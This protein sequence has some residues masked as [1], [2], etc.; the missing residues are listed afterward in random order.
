METL[1]EIIPKINSIK[2]NINGSKKS[3]GN[4]N[5][6]DLYVRKNSKHFSFE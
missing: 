2:T 4:L 3:Y 1:K 5:L 6:L